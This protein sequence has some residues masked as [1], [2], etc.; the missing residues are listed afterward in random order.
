MW[1]GG[2]RD[3]TRRRTLALVISVAEDRARGP[4]HHDSSRFPLERA[5]SKPHDD[6]GLSERSAARSEQVRAAPYAPDRL[7]DVRDVPSGGCLANHAGDGVTVELLLGDDL[8]AALPVVADVR[9][10]SGLEVAGQ[11]GRVRA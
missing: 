11:P 3:P 2:E 10:G 4:G 9:V 6:N 1:L 5:T 8:E 7:P